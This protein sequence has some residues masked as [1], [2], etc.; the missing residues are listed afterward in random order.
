[1]KNE[2]QLITYANRLGGETLQNLRK[3]LSGPLKGL[4]SCVHILPFFFPIDGADTGFDPIDHTKIDP[5]LGSWADFK[6]LGQDVDLMADLIVNHVSSFSPQFLDYSEK[7]DA[8]IYKNM[9]LTMASIF[10]NGATEADTDY[11]KG[12][13]VKWRTFAGRNR[14]YL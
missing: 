12:I 7:G 1:M 14:C 11:I 6:E 8:S 5:C 10:P 3:M 4:F 2:V 9:F 13:L